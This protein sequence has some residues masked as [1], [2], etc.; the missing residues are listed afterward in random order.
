MAFNQLTKFIAAARS[1]GI[2]SNP[3]CMKYLLA[4]SRDGK[5]HANIF[6]AAHIISKESNGPRHQ[7]IPSFAYDDIDN[8]IALCRACHHLIDH[9]Q[10]R[11]FYPIEKI[12]TWKLIAEDLATMRL[13]TPINTP[14]F[15]P[16]RERETRSK[17][18]D[19]ISELVDLHRSYK[20]NIRIG[21][22]AD[23][24]QG[25]LTYIIAGFGTLRR[26]DFDHPLRSH[27][28]LLS[29]HQDRFILKAN[30]CYKLLRRREWQR[31]SWINNKELAS[32]F[33]SPQNLYQISGPTKDYLTDLEQLLDE[34]ISIAFTVRDLPI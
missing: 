5:N 11:H 29:Y 15:D 31:W 6:E 19:H 16:Q 27:N 24:V 26:W 25:K 20:Q 4:P 14:F 8:C 17:F 2:C 7:S 9:S 28:S 22:M 3:E 30:E 23:R 34:L 1:G 21:L 12:K 33:E 18:I 32:I 13:N 10:N